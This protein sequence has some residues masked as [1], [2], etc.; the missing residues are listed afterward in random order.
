VRVIA[1]IQAR[2]NSARLPRKATLDINGKVLI[3]HVYDRLMAVGRLD[4]VAISTSNESPEIVGYCKINEIPHYVGSESDLLSRHLN[5]AVT[6]KADAVL[7]VTGDCIFHDPAMLDR[8]I[9]GFLESRPDALVNW[10]LENRTVSEGLDAEI[11]AVKA[12]RLLD[13]DRTCPREDWPTYMDRSRKFRVMGWAYNKRLGHEIHLSIDTP[14][15]LERARRM[16]EILGND[17]YGYIDT[18]KAW[19]ATK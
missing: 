17:T 9:G 15:D 13:S 14:S 1:L 16:L 11:V 4:G 10:H 2:D 18:L 5:A 7:R 12:M 3:Q 19:E 6:Y 8:M